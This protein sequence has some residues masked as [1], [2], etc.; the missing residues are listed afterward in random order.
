MISLLTA[1]ALTLGALDDPVETPLAQQDD[2]PELVALADALARAKSYGFSVETTTEM[3]GDFAGGGFGGGRGGP[4]ER[5]G[6]GEAGGG[7]AGGGEAGGGEAGGGE[8]G[9]RGERGGR[10]RGQGGFGFGQPVAVGGAYMSGLPMHL[11]SGG[12]E[13]YKEDD[14]LVFRNA[15]GEWQLFAGFGGRGGFEGRGRGRG[16]EGGGPDGGPEG[17]PE[18]GPE[19]RP[20]GGEDA[21]QVERDNMRAAMS[22]TGV[23]APHSLFEGFADSVSDVSKQVARPS[24]PDQPE[25]A[26]FAGVLSAEGASLLGG[27]GFGGRGGR[28]GWSDRSGGGGEGGGPQMETKGSFTIEVSAGSIRSATFVVTRSGSFG[29]RSFE[30]TTTRTIRFEKVGETEYEVPEEALSRFEV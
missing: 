3:G 4:G 15:A 20:T 29:E 30:R 26:V 28:A 27:G 5:P 12:A 17:R 24:A 9:G 16:G 6:G 7:E 2:K 23:Q 19:G 11:S 1:F 10:G 25:T 21:R 18:P 14:Q 13:A 8:A 22:F